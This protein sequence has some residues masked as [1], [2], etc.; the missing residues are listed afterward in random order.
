[1]LKL[2]LLNSLND[3]EQYITYIDYYENTKY[4]FEYDSHNSNQ[5]LHYKEES[6]K[7]EN[8]NYKNRPILVPNWYTENEAGATDL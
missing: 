6:C 2:I 8:I 5:T 4:V 7:I 1:M 3:G